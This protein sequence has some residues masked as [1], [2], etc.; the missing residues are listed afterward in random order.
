[1]ARV[2]RIQVLAREVGPFSSEAQMVVRSG[3]VSIDF[4]PDSREVHPLSSEATKW[5]GQVRSG[6]R[7][8]EHSL[9]CLYFLTD[10]SVS[11]GLLFYL[12]LLTLL[13][14]TEFYC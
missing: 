4:D 10:P 7:H 6:P 14:F 2:A 5:Y 12:L 3:P 13:G 11:K 1:M 9:I 8:Y